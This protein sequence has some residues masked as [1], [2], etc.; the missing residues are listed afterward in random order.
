MKGTALAVLA[1]AAAAGAQSPP[2]QRGVAVTPES[3]TVGDPFRVVIRVRAPRGTIL[4]FPAS[5]DSSAKVEPLDR[6][7]ITPGTD[8]TV[9]EQT[10][11]YRLAAW[12]VGRLPLR[13]EDIIVRTGSAERRLPVGRGLA[14]TVVSVLPADSAERV[15]RPVRPVYEFGVPWWAWLIVALAALVLGALLWWWWRRRPDTVAARP[16][17]YVAAMRD[18]D[19]IESLGLVA[20]GEVGHHLALTAD[21]LRM[22]LARVTPAARISLTTSELAG[23]L[24]ADPVVPHSRLVRTLHEID[25]VKF[26]RQR[27]AEGR[28]RELGSECRSIVIAVHEARQ[29]ATLA[30]AA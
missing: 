17:P 30:R 9:V 12:D 6:V 14:I 18:F 11:T 8:T 3:V 16:D 1:F 21:V 24:R 19:H 13:F 25:L 20:A 22:Y 28:A 7:S 29:A 5:P 27:V 23:A 4:E 26:A 10:A 15:P 2:L